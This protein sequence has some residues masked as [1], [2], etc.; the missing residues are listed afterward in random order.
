MT[1]YE[2][3]PEWMESFSYKLRLAMSKATP[4]KS[5]LLARETKRFRKNIQGISVKELSARSGISTI[6]IYAILNGN[7][8]KNKEGLPCEP[9]IETKQ[10]LLNNC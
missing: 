10:K 2:H 7:Y 8:K 9:K 4:T 3:R 6:A 5:E 1:N